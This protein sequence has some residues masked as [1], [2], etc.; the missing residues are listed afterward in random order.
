MILNDNLFLQIFISINLYLIF[1]ILLL[2]VN[3]LNQLSLSVFITNII[4]NPNH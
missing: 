2:E 1:L 3:K 4:N